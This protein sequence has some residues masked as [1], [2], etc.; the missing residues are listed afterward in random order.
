M[1][2]IIAGGREFSNFLLLCNVCDYLFQNLDEVEIISGMA[3]GADKLGHYYAKMRGYNVI[4]KPAPW[5]D[6]Q[7]KSSRELR[8]N[9]RGEKYWMLAGTF[10]NKE[11]ADEA[12]CLI[13]FW[14]GKSKG[15]RDMLHIASKRGLKIKIIKY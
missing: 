4:E 15:S 5:S 12:D 7:G 13:L 10:R 2:I 8:M 14:D 1:K 11:M 3:R 6:V 9:D